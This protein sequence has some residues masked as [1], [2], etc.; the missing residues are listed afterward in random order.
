[1]QR[2]LWAS[3]ATKDPAYRDVVYLEQLALPGTV[4]TVPEAT[5][6]AF[7][8]HGDPERTEPLGDEAAERVLRC[9]SRSAR[10][11]DARARAGGRRGVLRVVRELLA[12]IEERARRRR[13]QHARRIGG[14][15][16]VKVGFVMSGGASLGAIQAGMLLAL[17]ERDIAPDVIVGTSVGAINGAYIASRP[18]TLADRRGLG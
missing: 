2:P 11:G 3:T 5:L 7:A 17:F 8:D 9:R 16:L 1:M 18:P 10:P 12:C 4:L 15:D 14:G 13:R 6:R